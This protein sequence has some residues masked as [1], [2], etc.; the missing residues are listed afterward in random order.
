MFC[1]PLR[2]TIFLCVQLHTV[3]GY[4]CAQQKPCCSNCKQ[5]LPQRKSWQGVTPFLSKCMAEGQLLSFPLLLDLEF[6][7][8]SLETNI[9][10]SLETSINTGL[11]TS[12]VYY[13]GYCCRIQVSPYV[14][15]LGSQNFTKWQLEGYVQVTSENG[16]V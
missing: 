16:I 2:E 7:N 6:A 9:N 15:V 14:F 11:E 10:T 4:F 5:E 13:F 3:V 8:T 12:W 1:F